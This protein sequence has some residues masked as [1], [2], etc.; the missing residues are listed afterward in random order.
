M[1]NSLSLAVLGLAAV[2]AGAQQDAG[3]DAVTTIKM[4]ADPTAVFRNNVAGDLDGDGLVDVF[5]NRNDGALWMPNAG[6]FNSNI[7]LQATIADVARVRLGDPLP[8][9]AL[10]SLP[11]N[12]TNGGVTQAGADW[13]IGESY[14]MATVSTSGI[15]LLEMDGSGNLTTTSID[16]SV[17]GAHLV[18]SADV[19]GD[20]RR[21]IVA[22]EHDG[23]T[24]DVHIYLQTST[25]WVTGNT[26]SIPYV[27]ED[28]TN[29]NF[30]GQLGTEVAVAF[31]GGCIVY[32]TGHGAT[33]SAGDESFSRLIPGF[34][35]VQIEPLIG[36]GTG[37]QG[38]V[39]WSGLINGM[40]A[41]APL[42][43]SIAQ[44]ATLFSGV[45][46]ERLEV[47]HLNDDNFLDV[48]FSNGNDDNLYVLLG[49]N[50]D[51]QKHLYLWETTHNSTTT[52]TLELPGIVPIGSESKPL[53]QD[54]DDDGAAEVVFGLDSTNEVIIFEGNYANIPLTSAVVD[55][56]DWKFSDVG[57][58][59]VVNTVDGDVGPNDPYE[60]NYINATVQWSG[61]AINPT[62]G[63]EYKLYA[64]PNHTS[65][66][67]SDGVIGCDG[68][69]ATTS[70]SNQATIEAAWAD[71]VMLVTSS[72]YGGY[73]N[74]STIAGT[75]GNDWGHTDQ[76]LFFMVR[77]VAPN[78]YGRRPMITLGISMQE[79]QTWAQ[80]KSRTGFNAGMF[81]EETGLADLDISAYFQDEGIQQG[82][83]P[84]T[85]AKRLKRTG[86]GDITPVAPTDCDEAKNSGSSTGGGAS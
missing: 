79:D 8:Y 58:D 57:D 25:G 31:E 2:P 39:L 60:T 32:L 7:E 43:W 71:D 42:S 53:I 45:A 50:Y 24:T 12:A 4:S 70:T 47:G 22:F 65:L 62:Q 44:P 85:G 28:A 14:G 80:L 67:S 84:L 49:Q 37:G 27:V 10:G 74:A 86:F 15:N 36:Y 72:N 33:G 51:S 13:F 66:V 52:K 83:T 59:H 18:T 78:A 64:A 5:M 1:R 41:L 38:G 21:D 73:E 23:F 11:V 17:T 56:D 68:K 81:V 61:S 69:D 30:D 75:D 46:M 82:D 48:V 9:G 40:T 55:P 19:D 63:F 35:N 26:F 34:T 6:Y 20:K 3:A 29:I 76:V 54:L 77:P 16:S